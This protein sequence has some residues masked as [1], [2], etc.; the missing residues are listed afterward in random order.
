M[1]TSQTKQYYHIESSKVELF[2]ICP[3]IK[4]EQYCTSFLQFHHKPDLQQQKQRLC[5]K[6]YS[7]TIAYILVLY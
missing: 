5:S 3:Q 6:K 4:Y 1:K 2:Q 7:L